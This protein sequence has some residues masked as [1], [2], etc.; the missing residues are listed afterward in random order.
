MEFLLNIQRHRCSNAT[1]ITIILVN[2]I[3]E[4]ALL[5]KSCIFSMSKLDKVINIDA[6]KKKAVSF[7]LTS[8]S[9]IFLFKT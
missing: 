3:I 4:N 5:T 7:I 2:V 8:E 9:G 6:N 1:A